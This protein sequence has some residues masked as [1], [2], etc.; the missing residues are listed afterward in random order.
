MKLN[1]LYQI[2]NKKNNSQK[3]N[4]VFN[5]KTMLINKI[6]TNKFYY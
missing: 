1:T 3:D 5:N 2:K 6:V 4:K